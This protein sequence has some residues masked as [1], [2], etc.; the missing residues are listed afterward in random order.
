MLSCTKT[1][2]C[3][4]CGQPFLPFNSMATVCGPTCAGRWVRAKRAAEKATDKARRTALERLPELKAKAQTAVNA[5]VKERDKDQPCISCGK[6]PGDG[7]QFHGGRDSGHYRSVGSAPHMRYVEDN[8]N[9][10]C[11]KCNQH[12]GG[13]AVDYRLGL[14]A[15]IGLERVEALEADNTPRHYT[16]DELRAIAALYRAKLKE[17]KAKE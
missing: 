1:K 4:H 14:I 7:S 8:I 10:Q 16:H 6:P 12:K 17:L 15:R 5:W 11:V 13:N 3:A 9:S 2:P